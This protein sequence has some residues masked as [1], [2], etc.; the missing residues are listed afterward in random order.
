MTDQIQAHAAIMW[1]GD[2]HTFAI[3]I[4]RDNGNYQAVLVERGGAM[5]MPRTVSQSHGS[6]GEAVQDIERQLAYMVEEKQAFDGLGSN[7]S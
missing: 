4:L 7:A 1:P 6:E 2:D 3:Q 5:D